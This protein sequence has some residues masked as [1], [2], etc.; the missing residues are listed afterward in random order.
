MSDAIH[1]DL[2]E[3]AALSVALNRVGPKMIPEA[4]AAVKQS[5]TNIKNAARSKVSGHPSWKHL[6]ST[7][8]FDLAG[9]NAVQAA[10]V[11]GYEDRGQGELAGIA[12]FGSSRHAPHP[13]LMPA[14]QQE[15]PRFEKAMGDAVEKATKAAL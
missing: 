5:A 1:L 11:V 4:R 9:S 3:V 2:S 12:E 7:I 14:V 8:N 10:A 6:A 15:I 13:A